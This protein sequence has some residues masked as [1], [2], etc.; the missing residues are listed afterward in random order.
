MF[1]QAA[2]RDR[3]QA[4]EDIKSERRVYLGAKCVEDVIEAAVVEMMYEIA[5]ESMSEGNI[6]KVSAEMISG[7]YYPTPVW[8]QY[9]TYCLL[10]DI[11]KN[12]KKELKNNIQIGS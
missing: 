1:P 8:M 4:H 10:R 9:T 2:S 6:A 3:R 11:W 12:R 5:R 7:I